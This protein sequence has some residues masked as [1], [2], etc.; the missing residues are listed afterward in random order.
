MTTLSSD[1]RLPYSWDFLP[2]EYQLTRPICSLCLSN[3]LPMK[4]HQWL[5][6]FQPMHFIPR[7]I[8]MV[9]RFLL[10]CGQVQV[11]YTWFVDSCC[12]VVRYRSILL[13]YFKI[14]ILRLDYGIQTIAQLPNKTIL[15]YIAIKHTY[16]KTPL[17]KTVKHGKTVHN[18]TLLIIIIWDVFEQMDTVWSIPSLHVPLCRVNFCVFHIC[19]ITNTLSVTEA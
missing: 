8:H 3:F 11:T 7:I 10:C 14:S 5:S 13:K 2:I 4:K 6:H 15:K 18:N 17:N 16:H 1:E 12:V 19:I 9:R